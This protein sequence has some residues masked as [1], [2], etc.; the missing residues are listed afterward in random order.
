MTSGEPAGTDAAPAAE[1]DAAAAPGA[2][3]PDGDA[4]EEVYYQ[5]ARDIQWARGRVARIAADSPTG[6]AIARLARSA[7]ARFDPERVMQATAIGRRGVGRLVMGRAAQAMALAVTLLVGLPLFILAVGSV[8]GAVSLAGNLAGL[9]VVYAVALAVA[10]M[11]LLQRFRNEVAALE[12]WAPNRSLA[13]SLN[14]QSL[15][16]A[17]GDRPM[18]QAPWTEIALAGAE[19]RRIDGAHTLTAISVTAGPKA[20]VPIHRE[21]W[22]DGNDLMAQVL[23]LLV[24]NQRIEL[25]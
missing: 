11:A 5:P 8:S 25:V 13:L 21:L 2:A 6:L 22:D 4:A 24:A 19:T 16:V 12:R 15:S 17:A 14:R 20:V 18:L 9:A 10:A 3:Q 1:G 7:G 23:L